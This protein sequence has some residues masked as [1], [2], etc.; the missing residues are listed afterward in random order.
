LEDEPLQTSG[1]FT[2][3][4]YVLGVAAMACLLLFINGGMVMA[5]FEAATETGPRWLRN[6]QLMQFTLFVAPVVLLI[7]QWMIFDFVRRVL[8]K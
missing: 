4:F 7:L 2:G 8:R 5:F 1:C 6:K 3:C